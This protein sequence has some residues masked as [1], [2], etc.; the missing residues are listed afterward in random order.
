MQNKYTVGQ[1]FS[2]YMLEQVVLM[3]YK[4][5][6]RVHLTDYCTEKNPMTE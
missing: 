3:V 6:Q 2:F 4:V 1:I 5:F